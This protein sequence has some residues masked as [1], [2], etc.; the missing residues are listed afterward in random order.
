MAS[1]FSKRIFSL[2]IILLFSCVHLYAQKQQQKAFASHYHQG[3]TSQLLPKPE[4]GPNHGRMF[5]DKEMKIEM[6][7]PS[8]Q[9][10]PEVSYFIFDT[11][12]N[13]LEAKNFSGTV[14]YVFGGPNQYL[15][16][17]LMP[18]GLA[19]Q[20]IARLEDWNEY[21][22]AVVTLKQNGKVVC[23]V[24]FYNMSQFKDHPSGNTGHDYNA[25][26]N[27]SGRGGG[28]GGGG[29]TRMGR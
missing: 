17:N 23:S 14:K 28:H 18:S 7:T 1:Y 2:L 3:D 27:S 13:P 6:L 26:P 10:K 16:A 25:N 24:T 8:S 29:G 19:N 5:K 22:K 20:Y 15:E 4:K 11:L 21:K 9:K 12:N